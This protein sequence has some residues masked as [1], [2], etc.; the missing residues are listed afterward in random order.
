MV[1]LKLKGLAYHLQYT[2]KI[3]DTRSC[4]D[5]LS[6]SLYNRHLL[7]SPFLCSDLTGMLSSLY[8]SSSLPQLDLY[9]CTG[10]PLVVRLFIEP[11]PDFGIFV[12]SKDN[13]SVRKK[14]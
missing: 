8:L 2:V 10:F 6:C 13:S 11:H 3:M 1:L 7:F 14:S 4:D 5:L 12:V 9:V